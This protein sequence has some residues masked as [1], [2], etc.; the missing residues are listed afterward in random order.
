ME[1]MQA[2]QGSSFEAGFMQESRRM[3]PS[4][5]SLRRATA[6]DEPFLY[7]LY[8]STRA[9]ELAPVPWAPEQKDA[10]LRMQF[11]ARQHSYG[12]QF[13]EAEDQIV[14]R[15][16]RPAGRI[17]INR[18]PSGILLVDV[19]LLPEDQGLGIGNSL[20]KRLLD[21]ARETSSRVELCVDMGSR[22]EAL[23]VR[24]GFVPYWEDGIYRKMEWYPEGVA[25]LMGADAGEGRA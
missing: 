7:L 6:D 2:Y 1:M 14:L 3:D 13:P 5:Y 21:E 11:A 18:G 23:Y 22:A 19:A 10:F 24:F 4:S 9:E 15:D 12:Q 16:G 25:P 20:L 17:L 8:A